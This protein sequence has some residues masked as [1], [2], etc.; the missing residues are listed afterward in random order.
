MTIGLV[1]I[2]VAVYLYGTTLKPR[3][4][5]SAWGLWPHYDALHPFAY[6][7]T[8]WWRW[9]TNGF[10]HHDIVYLAVNMVVFVM[11]GRQVEAL[12]GRARFAILYG[13]SLLGASA[14]VAILGTAGTVSAGA[15]AANFG[16]VAGYVAIATTLRLSVKSV[17]LQAGAWLVIGFIVPG[18]SW[19]GLL[20]GAIAGWVVTMLILRLASRQTAP[21]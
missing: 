18:L 2:N 14:L 15:G 7:G 1:V 10:V 11:F 16:I 5:V 6:A 4:L 20:G 12:L 3:Q 13:A 21:K 19:Q 9:I 8:E 17:V